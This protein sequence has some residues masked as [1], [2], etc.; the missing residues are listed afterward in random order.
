M[1]D[2]DRTAAFMTVWAR[3]EAYGKAIGQGLDYRLRSVTVGASGSTI[4]GGAGDW[5][6]ADIDVD[7]TC[8]AAVVAQG[9]GWRVQLDRIERRTSV[10]GDVE[11]RRG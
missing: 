6:V 8:V 4:S 10:A 9:S 1:N 7:P 2:A 3:K 11:C 5:Q